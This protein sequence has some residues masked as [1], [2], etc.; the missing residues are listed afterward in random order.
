MEKEIVLFK[1]AGKQIIMDLPAP[2]TRVKPLTK[3]RF[4]LRCT[5]PYKRMMES[6]KNMMGREKLPIIATAT[7]VIISDNDCIILLT[8]RDIPLA[9]K[10][11]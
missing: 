1:V 5:V 8:T 7:D 2:P 9:I 10:F 3:G 6:V 11:T 4:A